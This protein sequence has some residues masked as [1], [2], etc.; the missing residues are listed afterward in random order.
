MIQSYLNHKSISK[1]RNNTN[2][3]IQYI[4]KITDKIVCR[5]IIGERMPIPTINNITKTC[6]WMIEQQKFDRKNARII[7]IIKVSIPIELNKSQR[8][9]IIKSFC[10]N[11]TKGRARWIAAIHDIH[12]NDVNSPHAHIIIRDRD[13]ETGYVVIGLS[14]RGST[15]LLREN[16]EICAN[17]YLKENGYK[18][19][20]HAKSQQPDLFK[21]NHHANFWKWVKEHK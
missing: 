15:A 8:I 6:N 17:T 10:E 12:K 5:E 13:Y 2:A 16:W 4:L 9:D 14:N 19:Q 11:I 18:I 1:C 7:D 20:I 3:S 21:V